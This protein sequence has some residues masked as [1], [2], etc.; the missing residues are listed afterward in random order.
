MPESHQTTST[1]HSA[2][3]S[4]DAIESSIGRAATYEATTNAVHRQVG[5][6]VVLLDLDSG[7]YFTL[8]GTGA[9]IWRHLMAGLT[10][11]EVC[12]A[13]T[14]TYDI[15]E[16]TAKFDLRQLIEQLVDH[17]LLRAA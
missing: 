17:N 10:V 13:I 16:A 5:S 12:R 1:V 9:D 6:D 7:T 11:A 14:F 8:S 15:D 4:P 3:A 2:S